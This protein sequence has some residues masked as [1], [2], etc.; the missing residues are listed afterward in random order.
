MPH[1]RRHFLKSAGTTALSLSLFPLLT[2]CEEPSA[3]ISGSSLF[4]R[5]SPESQGV[6]SASIQAFLKAANESGLEWH[7]FML[8]RHG[9]V[10]AE[11]WWDPFGPDYR[12]MLYSLSKSFT[13]TAVGLVVEDGLL[14]IDTTVASF[15]PDQL[16]EN[17]DPRLLR[18]T[19]RHLLTMNTGHGSDSWMAIIKDYGSPWIPQFLAHP[20][21]HEPGTHFQYDTGATY[22]LS[23]IVQKVSGKTVE[24]V[25]AD[26]IFE[27]LGIEQ[28]DW[29]TSPEGMNSGGIGL[30]VTTEAIARLGQLYLQKG[31]W[32]G[33]QLISQEWVNL[34]TSKQVESNDGDGDWS[35]GYGFQFWRSRHE[36]YR[37]D[38]A[39]GQFCLVMPQYDAVM[40][41]TSE[42]FDMGRSMD[43]VWE[44]ILPA[45]AATAL[46]EAPETLATLGQAIA[47]LALPT[48]VGLPQ[49]ETEKR[50]NGKTFQFDRNEYGITEISCEF[51]NQEVNWIQK[52]DN[53][54]NALVAG[55]QSWRTNTR[56]TK[57]LF[58]AFYR[59]DKPSLLAAN[60]TWKDADT[61][62]IHLKQVEGMHGDTITMKFVENEVQISFL[63]SIAAKYD[64]ERNHERRVAI[65]GTMKA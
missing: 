49:P 24:Q 61:L 14:S 3:T 38:G 63:H 65:T 26:R 1:T 19:V 15:F 50:L 41:I 48:L 34:A 7:S 23:A 10:I 64:D 53:G 6:S 33:E 11:G 54:A 57:N 31:E 17:P 27:S 13:S 32:E 51:A 36:T 18:M 39:Y 16:P 21:E 9:K 5:A 2:A 52:H 45:F 29:E 60:Y 55:F 35:Q 28:H 42:S 4:S 25:L 44:H 43:I 62:V 40:A 20:M 37:G 47:S 59:T 22:M 56:E 12:H 58:P 46:P 30:R 8:L